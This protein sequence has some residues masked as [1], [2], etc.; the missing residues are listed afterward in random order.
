MIQIRESTYSIISQFQG[1]LIFS[2]MQVS[3]EMYMSVVEALQP[4]LYVTMADEVSY[5]LVKSRCLFY[6]LNRC[7]KSLMM[8]RVNGLQIPAAHPPKLS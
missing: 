2:D 1:R 5:L 4:D 6:N 8:Q 3:P 7:F